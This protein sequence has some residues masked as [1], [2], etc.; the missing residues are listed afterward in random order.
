[1]AIKSEIIADTSGIIALL[2]K[3]D[4]HHYGVLE[5]IQNNDILIPSSIL[6]EG[7]L[8]FIFFLEDL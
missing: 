1:M 5:I 3:S 6:P 2:D 7:D 4:K 8:A